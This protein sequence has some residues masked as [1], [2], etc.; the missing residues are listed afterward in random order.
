MILDYFQENYEI[1]PDDQLTKSCCDLCDSRFN[2]L[3]QLQQLQENGKELPTEDL[4]ENSFNPK[5]ISKEVYMLLSLI[6]DLRGLYGLTV[7]ISLLHGKH[8]KNVAR[9]PSYADIEFFGK[10]NT[11][12]SD[13]WKELSNQLVEQDHY[14]EKIVV[15][16][17]SGYSY[18]KYQLTKKGI[19]FLTGITIPASSSANSKNYHHQEINYFQLKKLPFNSFYHTY[20]SSIHPELL[21]IIMAE[22][23][24]KEINKNRK[25]CYSYTAPAYIPI[26]DPRRNPTLLV[27]SSSATGQTNGIST[28]NNNNTVH[29]LL[30]KEKREL[31]KL[32]KDIRKLISTTFQITPYQLLTSLEI[33][34]LMDHLLPNNQLTLNRFQNEEEFMNF[35]KWPEWKRPHAK[36]LVEQLQ[37]I[38]SLKEN[39]S[40]SSA[41][42]V[43]TTSVTNDDLDKKDSHEKTDEEQQNLSKILENCQSKSLYRPDYAKRPSPPKPID[44]INMSS[45]KVNVPSSAMARAASFPQPKSTAAAANT[46]FALYRPSYTLPRPSASSSLTAPVP[47]KTEGLSHQQPQKQSTAVTTDSTEEIPEHSASDKGD[48]NEDDGNDSDSTCVQVISLPPKQVEIISIEDNGQEEETESVFDDG[49][50]KD[51][52]AQG[53]ENSL[54]RS[55]STS[56][57]TAM[58]KAQRKRQFLA[59]FA[60]KP[61]YCI[62]YF[63]SFDKRLIPS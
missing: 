51:S 26:L 56:S 23:Q 33:F 45:K 16:H 37:T 36:A 9:I 44:L 3:Q 21:K 8:D 17:G 46:S 47:C 31:E 10:G 41:E 28:S 38:A 53:K 42:P 24:V 25:S 58:L 59:G 20:Q 4:F 61:I 62:V 40:A 12:S 18:L 49:H 43:A 57:T 14:L 6:F 19:Y 52:L 39:S 29:Y 63:V 30:S 60:G 48:Q 13:W 1:P 50:L 55:F 7:V 11:H 22:R 32:L 34:E 2:E 15:Q 27:S 5:E 54:N 35:L